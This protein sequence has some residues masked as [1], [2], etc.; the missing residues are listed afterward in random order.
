MLTGRSGIGFTEKKV[1]GNAV[2]AMILGGALLVIHVA[3]MILSI[4]YEGRLPFI[5][6]VVESYLMLF[7]VF[8]IFWAVLSYDDEKTVNKYKAIGIILNGMALVLAILVMAVG[9]MTY[10]I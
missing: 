4:G 8:G 10:E 3:L 1:S 7:S 6:G 2:F 9:F 5:S